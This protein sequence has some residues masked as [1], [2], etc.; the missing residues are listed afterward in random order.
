[1][2][3]LNQLFKFKIRLIQEIA[4]LTNNLLEVKV[5]VH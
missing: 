4:A 1:M 2:Y 5:Q 3:R